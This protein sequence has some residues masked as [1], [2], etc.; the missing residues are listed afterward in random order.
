MAHK[1]SQIN[2]S[3]NILGEADP[4][5]FSLAYRVSQTSLSSL[6][7]SRSVSLSNKSCNKI[8]GV[9]VLNNLHLATE[10]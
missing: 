1:P 3:V 10:A 5:G 4:F 8:A 2:C 7:S 9:L 6:S